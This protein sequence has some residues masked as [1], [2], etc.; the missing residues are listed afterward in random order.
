MVRKAKEEKTF[1]TKAERLALLKQTIKDINKKHPGSAIQIGGLK[2]WD[3]LGSGIPQV[4]ELLGG[5]IPYGTFTTI[6]GGKSAGKTTLALNMVREAQKQGKIVYYIA[7]EPLDLE[8]AQQLG[9]NTDELMVGSFPIAEHS[10]DSIIDVARQKLVDVIILDSIHSLSPKSEQQE[11][12]GKEKS[13]EDDTMALLARKL[14]QFF[15]VAVHPLREG[16]IACLLIGQT[17]TSIGFI[18]IEQ[19]SGGNALKHYSKLILH[20]TRGQKA[21]A[22]TATIVDEEGIK[23]KVIVGFESK[24]KIDTTQISGTKPELT[25]LSL[26]YKFENGF[27]DLLEEEKDES[28]Q[29]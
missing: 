15:R 21:N 4:D 23:Q 8:R 17:R 10:L 19:L 6:W 2:A 5:G 24:L 27:N 9:V 1:S 22:P 18:A 25:L 26:P 7:L 12:T 16:N 20:M 3:K 11:K 28:T 13:M 29:A 14:S